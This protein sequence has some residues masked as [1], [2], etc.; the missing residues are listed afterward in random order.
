MEQVISYINQFI[1]LLGM[2][3]LIIIGVILVLFIIAIVIYR[4]LRLKVCRSETGL[5][6]LIHPLF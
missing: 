5:R 2:R 6:H 1:A 3:N 4:S